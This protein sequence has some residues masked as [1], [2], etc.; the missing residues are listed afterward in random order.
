MTIIDHCISDSSHVLPLHSL[1]MKRLSSSSSTGGDRFST[2]LT[3]IYSIPEDWLAHWVTSESDLSATDLIAA[4]KYDPEAITMLAKQ[5]LQLPSHL[6]WPDAANVC[7]FMFWMLSKRHAYC[8]SRIQGIRA[9]SNFDPK[10][11]KINLKHGGAYTMTFQDELLCKITHVSGEAVEL[12]AK[13]YRITTSYELVNN[14][15]D[16][17]AALVLDP[18]P[19]VKLI[20]FFTTKNTGPHEYVQFKGGKSLDFGTWVEEM[21]REWAAT[22]AVGAGDST[23]VELQQKLQEHQH[24]TKQESMKRA[25][26]NAQ[27]VLQA[28]NQKRRI[29]LAE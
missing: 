28:R 6:K 8:G 18:L 2:K 10:V 11:G 29:S 20:D 5:A 4:K 26:V 24:A 12:D 22:R 14:H 17:D 19:P 13:V 23:R 1:L 21:R 9:S 7:E 27:Q 15:S 16:K 3:T 25:R